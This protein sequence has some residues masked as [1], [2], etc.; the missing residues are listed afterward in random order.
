MNQRDNK[1]SSVEHAC[2]L[3]HVKYTCTCVYIY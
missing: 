2:T 3:N 1:T